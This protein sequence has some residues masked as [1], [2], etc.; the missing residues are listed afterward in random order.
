L[1]IAALSA[2]GKVELFNLT[3]NV[4]VVA[5]VVG[6][7]GSDPG[8]SFVAQAP[9][10]VL[11]TRDSNAPIAQGESR[12]L[13][14]GGVAGVPAW[15]TA[16][17]FNLTATGSDAPTFLTASPAGVLRPLASNLN[18]FTGETA[19]NLVVVPIGSAGAISL[20]N[21]TGSA[22][23]IVDIVGWFG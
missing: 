5:D 19:A 2:D 17:V 18:I 6:W 20:Y 15:A 21:N 3:G 10:R 14:V 4:E 7:Y 12:S 11:D 22:H 16:V 1:V 8:D 23:V 9:A 13:T